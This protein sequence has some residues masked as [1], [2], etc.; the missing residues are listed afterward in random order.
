L[1]AIYSAFWQYVTDGTPMLRSLPLVD[2]QNP[3]AYWRSAEFYFGDH[4][5]VVPIMA[6]GEEGRF[7][8]L[9]KS[10]WFS[11]HDDSRPKAVATDIWI[12]SPIDRIPVFVRAGAVIPHWPLQQYVGQIPHPEPELRIWWKNGAELSRWYED[13]GDGEAWKQD[14]Y[15]DSELRVDGD[16]ERITLSRDWRGSWRPGYQTVHLTF[17]GV[18]SADRELKLEIDGCETL[19][20]RGDDGRYH[21][22]APP[23]FKSARLRWSPLQIEAARP[24]S[25]GD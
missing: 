3:D 15:R 9:P 2:Y 24:E 23:D 20:R 6:E 25:A 22:T 7:L 8:Y 18:G 19:A 21:A 11:Y 14:V 13:D 17:C 12:E 16:H 1:P 4:L 5:Y 10:E